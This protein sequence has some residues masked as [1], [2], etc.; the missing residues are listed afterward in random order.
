LAYEVLRRGGDSG[1]VLNAAD[2][3]LTRRF[4]DGAL[5]FPAIT[6]TAADVVR[7]RPSRPVRTLD[8]VRR[9]DADG[10]AAARTRAPATSKPP[11]HG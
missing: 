1:A 4:L 6:A 3:V 11:A 9:A 8:D 7:G 10:R 5:P 2:E